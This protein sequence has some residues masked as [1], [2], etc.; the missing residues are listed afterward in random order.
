MEN[1]PQAD[2]IERLHCNNCRNETDHIVLMAVQDNDKNIDGDWSYLCQCLGCHEVVLHQTRLFRSESEVY[3]RQFPPPVSRDQPT[4]VNKLPRKIRHVLIEMYGSLDTN[5]RSLPMM[6]A[7]TLLDLLILEK[8]GDVGTFQQKLDKLAADG[9]IATKQVDVLTAALD[10][11]SAAIHR[12]HIPSESN[13][14]AVMDIIENLLNAV[15]V[16]PHVA[17]SVKRTTPTRPS[18]HP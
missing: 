10:A 18:K 5:A 7:R 13:V 12:G 14:N 8:V 1:K 11:G 3:H 6:G 17:K 15:Y 2:E 9:F 4:W 16:L